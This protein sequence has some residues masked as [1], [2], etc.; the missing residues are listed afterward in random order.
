ME[1]LP[2][3]PELSNT[4]TKSTSLEVA[5][6]GVTSKLQ[7][8]LKDTY[9]NALLGTSGQIRFGLALLGPNDKPR[10]RKRKSDPYEGKWLQAGGA[11]GGGYQM[12]YVPRASGKFKLHVWYANPPT[13]M[14]MSTDAV[15]RMSTDMVGT[16]VCAG[17]KSRV[18]TIR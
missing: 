13:T 16:R 6:A 1:L 10:R 8:T 18:L 2:G 14:S 3:P 5:T 9:G 15:G 12:S 7:V 11:E 17:T 4:D